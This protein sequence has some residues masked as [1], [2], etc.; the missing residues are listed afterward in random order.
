[1]KTNIKTA[2]L[3]IALMASV[4][5]AFASNIAELINGKKINTHSWQKYLPDGVTPIGAPV[6]GD[7]NGPFAEECTGDENVC[8]VGT[9]FDENDDVITLRYEEQSK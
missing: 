9:P 7:S 6:P 8:A 5:G 4:T 3:G 2:I 1:M